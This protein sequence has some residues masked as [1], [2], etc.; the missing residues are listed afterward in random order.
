MIHMCSIGSKVETR[1]TQGA[2]IAQH[3]IEHYYQMRV[4]VEVLRVVGCT[5]FD[6]KVLIFCLSINFIN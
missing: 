2:E 4:P 1:L 3:G 6:A 5:A